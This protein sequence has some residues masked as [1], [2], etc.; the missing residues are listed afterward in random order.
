MSD[1]DSTNAWVTVA[2]AAEQAQVDSGTIRQWYRA[3]R[4]PTRRAEG[5]RGAFLV[6]LSLV[7]DLVHPPEVRAPASAEP[8]IDDALRTLSAESAAET[9]GLR[10]EL[11]AARQQ[12]DFLRAQLAEA[13]GETR[14]LK[15]Q[16]QLADDQR[17]DLR[18]QLADAVDERKGVEARLHTVEAELAEL[19]K[20]A[21]R[22]SITD[23]SWLD[24]QTPAYQSPVRRQAMSTPPPAP[25]AAP[26]GG[27]TAPYEDLPTNDLA[28]LLAA[29][30]PDDE[31]APA[32]TSSSDGDDVVPA[33][34]GFDDDDYTA[35][36]TIWTDEAPHPPLGE[37]P[38]DLL[39]EPDKK[40]RRGK[41]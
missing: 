17:A 26:L 31:D 10:Q 32:A 27:P 9:D 28:D 7:L 5:Q 14:T 35:S 25:S 15:Q 21:A 22:S 33:M 37:N 20:T 36:R 39:P 18:A 12:L 1:S 3:G 16:L 24:L 34:R 8:S 23:N 11:D 29:T 2:E 38:D 41:R 13:A 30:R 40:G 6:P 4:I 19:R